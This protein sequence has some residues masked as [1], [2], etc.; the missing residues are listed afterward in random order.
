MDSD[1]AQSIYNNVVKKLIDPALLE[2]MGDNIF[3]LS[4]FPIEP[5]GHQM[6]E[7]RIEITYAELLPYDGGNISYDF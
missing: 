4:V 3:K 6:S 7:R 2:Y 5:D 1:T